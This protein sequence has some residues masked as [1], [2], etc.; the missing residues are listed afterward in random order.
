MAVYKRRYNSY[1]GSL[2]PQWSRFFVLTRYA[3]VDLFKARFSVPLLILSV[4]LCLSFAAY[5]FIATNHPIQPLMQVRSG[6]LLSVESK[7]FIVIMMVQPQAA[8][9]VNSRVGPV[10]ISG[11]LPNGALPLS[12]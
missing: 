3:F 2:T 4:I 6:D 12:L 10:L 5:I 8:F 1:A 11:E 7:Y 9:L